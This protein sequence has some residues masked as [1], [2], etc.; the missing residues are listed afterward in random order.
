MGYRAGRV[1]REAIPRGSC[2]RPPYCV[3]IQCS[4]VEIYC[5]NRSR[6]PV[7]TNEETE[8]I[9][10]IWWGNIY[11]CHTTIKTKWYIFFNIIWFVW[12]GKQ[13]GANTDNIRIKVAT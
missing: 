7:R 13:Q 8:H 6:F 3:F 12:E 1:S 9:I 10:H 5:N 2:S 11:V 4:V